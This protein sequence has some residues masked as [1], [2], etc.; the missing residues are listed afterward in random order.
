[1]LQSSARGR[2]VVVRA[3]LECS[4]HSRVRAP[5]ACPHRPVVVSLARPAESARARPLIPYL[6]REL[7]WEALK[8]ALLGVV[9]ICLLLPIYWILSSSIKPERDFFVSPPAFLFTPTTINYERTLSDLQFLTYLRNSLVVSLSTTGVTLAV[10]S[11]AAHALAR[12]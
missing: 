4:H 12:Y 9:L 7:A 8:Y 3:G 10:A 6:S 1:G 5:A 2:C 11:L